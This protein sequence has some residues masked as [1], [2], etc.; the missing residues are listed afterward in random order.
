MGTNPIFV[1]TTIQQFGWAFEKKLPE[2]YI[3]YTL[4]N[5]FLPQEPD[6]KILD[7][8]GWNG[9]YDGYE[10]SKNF[11]YYGHNLIPENVKLN[12]YIQSVFY[13]HKTKMY[14]LE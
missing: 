14:E 12:Q 5:F 10:I 13:N 1:D 3:G 8:C 2:I 6:E 9:F 4:P 7:D 11:D